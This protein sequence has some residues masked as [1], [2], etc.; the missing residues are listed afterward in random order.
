MN[1]IMYRVEI[2]LLIGFK[3]D[4]A[5]VEAVEHLLPV[6]GSYEEEDLNETSA[7]FKFGS[8]VR[9]SAFKEEC[10]KK[11]LN[12]VPGIYYVDVEY[13]YYGEFTPDRFVM[14][15]D[16]RCAEFTGK[17]IYTEDPK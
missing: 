14:W 12:C 9:V 8:E 3:I 6:Y 10:V 5:W 17:V 16:G 1:S 15:N 11:L 13:I 4:D 7:V 2:Q